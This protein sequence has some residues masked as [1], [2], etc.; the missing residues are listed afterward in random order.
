M[1]K[2]SQGT[3]VGAGRT[4][5]VPVSI[6]M[7]SILTEIIPR[8]LTCLVNLGV[9]DWTLR[10]FVWLPRFRFESTRDLGTFF[11]EG[12]KN[13]SGDQVILISGLRTDGR[14]LWAM[15]FGRW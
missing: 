13:P 4:R 12:N 5:S 10:L 9:L 11:F 1:E 8:A 6:H 3:P 2:T 14:S 7:T 15:W